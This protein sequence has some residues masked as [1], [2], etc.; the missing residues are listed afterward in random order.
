MS[1]PSLDAAATAY[2]R[3]MMAKTIG[4][5]VLV[6]VIWSQPRIQA[7]LEGHKAGGSDASDVVNHDAERSAPL[8]G[9]A[10]R[11]RV[12]IKDVNDSPVA[13]VDRHDSPR[14]TETAIPSASAPGHY[15]ENSNADQSTASKSQPSVE[16]TA[17]KLR[18]IRNNVFESTSGLRYMPGSADNHRLRHVMQHAKDDTSKVIHGVFEGNLDQILAVIDEAYEKAQKGGRDVRSEEQNDRLVYTVNLWRK[19]G[20]TGGSEGKR[21]GNPECHYLRIILEDI[22]VVI[23]AY[24]T[25]S[26]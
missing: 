18:E 15:H 2:R 25:Q 26:F 9:S 24:P 13:E 5:V 7:W 10:D 3:K 23:T 12:I 4:F 16:P 19:I 22:N 1:Q 14:S 20:Y 11:K 6:T 8:Q 17:G 21:K